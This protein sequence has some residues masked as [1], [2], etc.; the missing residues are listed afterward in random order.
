MKFTSGLRRRRQHKALMIRRQHRLKGSMTEG[1]TEVLVEQN[2]FEGV[3]TGLCLGRG[4]N[5][6]GVK[7][8]S[9]YS[10]ITTVST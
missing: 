9:I 4:Q 5:G 3:G 8:L 2:E 10:S 6:K 1:L 7:G